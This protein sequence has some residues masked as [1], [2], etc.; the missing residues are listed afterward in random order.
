M[1]AR[2]I[3]SQIARQLAA[4]IAVMLALLLR[5]ALAEQSIM[6]PTYVTFYPVV[7]LAAVIGGMWAGILATTFS[8]VLADYFLLDPV[9]Q[10][11]IHSASDLV[12]LAIFCSSGVLVSVV[13]E[14]YHRSRER[15]A[16]RNLE[17]AVLDERINVEEARDLA[18]AVRAERLR[19]LEVL[20][21]LRTMDSSADSSE[22]GRSGEKSNASGEKSSP[23]SLDQARFRASL[24]SAVALPL[25][26]ALILAGAAL[27]A[28]YDLNSSM[29]WVDHTDQVIGRSQHLLKLLVDMETGERGYLVTGNDVF[30]QP[31]QDASNAVDPEYQALYRLVADTP[32]Q[33]VRLARLHGSIRHWQG[34]AEQMI[35][36]RRTG[37]AYAEFNV[38]LAGKAEVD[39]IREQMTGFQSVEANLR[40]ERISTAHRDWRLVATICILLGLVVGAGL[41]VFTR[42]RMEAIASSFEKSGRALAESERRWATML[43]SIGDAVIAADSHGWV[44]FLNPAASALT[45]WQPE[46]ALG[47]PIQSVFRIINEKTRAPAEDI[48]NRVLQDGR[49]VALANHTALQ[50]KDGREIPIADSAAPI[51]DS[52]GKIAGVVLVFRDV[53]ERRRAENILETTL[54][55]FY[56]ILS[57]MNSGVLLVTNEGG[58]EFANQAFCDL[59]G[60]KESPAELAE[61][62]DSEK[63]I[64][65]IEAAYR[66]PGQAVLR[67]REL[68]DRGQS[69]LSEEVLMRNGATYLRDFVPLTVDGN[70]YGRMWVHT[71]IT[72]RVRGEQA[73]RENQA[74][75][76]AALANMTD[77]VIITDAEGRFVEFNDAFVRFYRFKSRDECPRNFAEFAS[78]FD[79]FMAN[80]EPAP[81]KMFAIQR[82][83][84]GETATNAEYTLRR[85][86]T[87][88]SWIGSISFSPIRDNDG[89]ITGS[90]ITARDI[91]EAK[92][93]EEERQIAIDFLGMV[94]QSRGTGDL[95]Q[96]A[97]TF[98]QERSGCEAVGIRLRE[99]DDYPYIES[100]GFSTEFVSLESR[101]CVRAASGKAMKDSAGKPVLECLCGNVIRG[102]CEAS[103]PFYTEHGSFW[104]NS[105]TDL[106]ARAT[107]DDLPSRTRNRCNREGYESVALFPIYVGEERFGLVQLN[108]RHKGRFSAQSIVLWERLAGHLATAVSKFQAEEA[109]QESK[110]LLGLFVEH[111]PAALAM[112]DDKMRYLHA[113]RRWKADSGLGDRKLR[114]VSHYEV[115]PEVPEQW[116]EAHRRGLAGEVLS[117]AA[118]RFE[119]ADGSEQW[120]RWEVR[121]WH[122]AEGN[123]GGIVI[124][125]EDVT[126]RKAAEAALLRSEKVAF[127]R[128]QLQAL[129]ERLRQAREEERKK[130]ARDLHDQIGQILTAIKMDMSWV[131]RHLPGSK[132][133]LHERLAGSIKMVN[134][135]VR[136]VRSI[137]S[138]LRPGVLDDLGLAAAIEWQA[139]EFASRTG[140]KCEVSVPPVELKLDGDRATALFRIFQECLTNVARHAEAQA[141]HTSLKEQDGIVLLVVEDNG[142]GFRQ[143]EVAGSL[144]VLGMKE[145]AQVCGGDVQ[146]SSAP[147]K[148]TTVTVRVPVRAASVESEDYAHSAGR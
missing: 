33:Q 92:R 25:M 111:A 101:L 28:A 131:V 54:Q 79:A 115:F 110:E 100:R 53:T 120:V 24:R 74:K 143:S 118:D 125:S 60:L 139:N 147:G 67:I 13:T 113:S 64:A 87:G 122:D 50:A 102:R 62:F 14:L 137:C 132:D 91:T 114:G 75:L 27:W 135:G 48:V 145:R 142:K 71:D 90:V 106:I 94:N 128:Q 80:G 119:R 95:L 15:R 29:Q 16:A 12:G 57:N 34:Y 89:A 45:G 58:I 37:G 23:P 59:I 68:L 69:A 55:R 112:F 47:R 3:R 46:D 103:K 49:V 4:A 104:S 32:P 61:T 1:I 10:F 88:E 99:G 148:G 70:S 8:A 116:K 31:Y 39:E 43:A 11:S 130:V 40:D 123:V 18:E 22:A 136:S 134:E 124:F 5:V 2:I 66:N 72:E 6:L 17:T 97:A 35:A 140:I 7:F 76:A 56:T 81:R 98:F 86:D 127:Q 84:R 141:V 20:E 109:L 144:G 21:S 41:A 96:R 36:L 30:L 85:K 83:L 129:A 93:A 19:F 38:N 107:K 77:S 133:E 65:K 121:P 146:V 63:M 138:G 105:T 26:A 44:T 51:L 9:G 42:R 108:D 117:G 52:A 73:L 126:E 78:L 82:A